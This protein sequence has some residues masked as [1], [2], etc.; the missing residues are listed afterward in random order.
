MRYVVL[1][2]Y[3]FILFTDNAFGAVP[4]GEWGAPQNSGVKV[5]GTMTYCAVAA[6]G[7]DIL[8]ISSPSNPTLVAN[9]KFDGR[10]AVDVT[11]SGDY[12]FVAAWDIEALVAGSLDRSGIWIMVNP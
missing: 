10:S 2:V 6:G 3:F 1:C 8:D 7:L 4:V 12:V 9:F 5:D 11:K